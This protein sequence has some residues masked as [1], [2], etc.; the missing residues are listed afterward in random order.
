VTNFSDLNN[1]IARE[2]QNWSHEIEEKLEEVKRDVA[3]DVNK[4]LKTKKHTYTDRTGRYKK[5]W[6][7]KKDNQSK[8]YIVHN[9]TDYQLTHLLEKGHAKRGGGRVDPRVHIDPI[10]N[11][12][13]EDFLRRIEEAIR[14]D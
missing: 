14:G 9:K 2:L 3:K 13:I 11:K 4:S 5:G 10:E 7:I 8:S 1:A 6:R 12:A